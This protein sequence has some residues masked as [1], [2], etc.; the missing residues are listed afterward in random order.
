MN[1]LFG[2]AHIWQA[3]DLCPPS[4]MP[5]S[6][7]LIGPQVLECLVDQIRFKWCAVVE[8]DRARMS[9]PAWVLLCVTSALLASGTLGSLGSHS[10][11]IH[12]IYPSIPQASQQQKPRAQTIQTAKDAQ[13]TRS[14][15]R[16]STLT[17]KTASTSSSFMVQRMFMVNLSAHT[18]AYRQNNWNAFSLPS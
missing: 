3:A 15:Q 16:T 17:G 18:G 13:M 4:F 10:R 9:S 14:R 2:A 12:A 7:V 5:P 6:R 1:L 8:V 11:R